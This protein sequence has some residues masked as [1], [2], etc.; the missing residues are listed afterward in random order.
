MPLEKSIIG[1]GAQIEERGTRLLAI[2]ADPRTSVKEKVNAADDLYSFLSVEV[3]KLLKGYEIALIK[4][5][6]K[7]GGKK[8]S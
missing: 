5:Q 3:P 6:H 2:V 8:P 4:L 1:L 7:K